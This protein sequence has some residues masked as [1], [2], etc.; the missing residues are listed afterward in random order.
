MSNHSQLNLH[1]TFITF[2]CARTHA[3]MHPCAC[4]SNHA[5]VEVRGHVGAMFSFCLVDPGDQIQLGRLCSKCLYHCTSP[6]F[7]LT[8]CHLLSGNW[9]PGSPWSWQQINMLFQNLLWHARRGGACLLTPAH[10]RLSWKISDLRL[11][12]TTHLLSYS[13]NKLKH[14]LSHPLARA[15]GLSHMN[16]LC[17]RSYF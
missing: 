9:V 11:A 16:L 6:G 14:S 2:A 12:W 15:L 1:K 4:A 5:C 13:L 3:C 10:R 7:A 8:S 17:H